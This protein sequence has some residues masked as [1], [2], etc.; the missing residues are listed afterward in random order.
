M[1]RPLSFLATSAYAQ[2]FILSIESMIADRILCSENIR[3][4]HLSGTQLRS[5]KFQH[6][7]S[8]KVVISKGIFPTVIEG[9][10]FLAINGL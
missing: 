9:S 5:I 8:R 2:D 1:N 10:I 6:V 4:L 7:N 3:Y